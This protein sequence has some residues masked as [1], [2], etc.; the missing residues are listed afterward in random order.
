MPILSRVGR[1]SRKMRFAIALIYTALAVG[2]LSMLYP[3]ILMLS[4]SVHSDTDFVWVTPVPEYLFDD[5]VLWMKYIESKYGLLPDAEAA[6]QLTDRKL[7]QH[8]P[9]RCARHRPRQA[10]RRVPPH[11]AL[12]GRVVHDG[13][14]DERAARS[15]AH[16]GS[17]HAKVPRRRARE[18]QEYPGLLRRRRHPLSRV[19]L[20]RRRRWSGLRRGASHSP[21]PRCLPCITRSRRRRRWRIASW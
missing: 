14:R 9:A 13:P 6:L 10:V 19:V 20:R 21:T 8:P 4:G 18:I 17:E 11:R 1:R 2:G 7:A 15:R 12:A 5:H 16:P 3:M